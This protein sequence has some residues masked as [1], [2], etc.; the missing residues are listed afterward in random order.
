MTLPLAP[1]PADSPVQRFYL[2]ADKAFSAGGARLTM[3][4]QLS[5][6]GAGAGVQLNWLYQ[7]DGQWLPLGQ[8][9][10]DAEQTG[11]TTFDFH[12]GTR[13]FTQD[14]EISFHVPMSWPS[15]LYRSR[16]GRWL[17]IDVASGQ[18]ATPPTAGTL[19]VGYEWLLPQMGGI[20]ARNPAWPA[21]GPCAA[22]RRVLQCQRS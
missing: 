16:T 21:R 12:D 1:F 6:P 4:V 14:G 18:Y 2:S 5:Q 11:D 9:S 19:T 3:Q 10:S 8:S 22:P 15:S 13:A 20:T 17:R 7:A